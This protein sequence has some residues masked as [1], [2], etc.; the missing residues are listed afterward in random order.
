MVKPKSMTKRMTVPTQSAGQPQPTFTPEQSR[1]LEQ[2]ARGWADVLGLWRLCRARKCVRARA[3]R[4]GDVRRC[5]HM[6]FPLLPDGLQLWFGELIAA[7]EDG[8]SYDQALA[9]MRG[10]E[11][12]DALER[13][14]RAIEATE[15]MAGGGHASGPNA[16]E[17]RSGGASNRI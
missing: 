1:R 2:H 14:H 17:D 7:Q 3:C 10:S 6:H 5:F 15:I 16:A 8:L 9:R 12:E 13:W 4:G 11:A